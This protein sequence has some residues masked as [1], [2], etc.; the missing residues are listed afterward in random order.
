[1]LHAAYYFFLFAGVEGPGVGAAEVAADTARHGDTLRIKIAA[2]RASEAFR[3]AGKF[4]GV[5]A[6]VAFVDWGVRCSK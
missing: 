4:A 2:L 5:V 1:M 3:C 6:V